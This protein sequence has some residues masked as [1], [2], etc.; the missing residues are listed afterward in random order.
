MPF[1]VTMP[2][3]SP[4]MEEGVIAKWHKK[5]GDLVK[6]GDLLIEVATDKATV[7]YNA[8]DGG[9]L[10][11]IIVP[12]GGKAAIN[13]PVA[14]FS[15]TSD[16]EIGPYL[17]QLSSKKEETKAA[18]LPSTL[19][20]TISEESKGL[21][22]E[23]VKAS[24]LAKKLAKQQGID[25]TKIQGSGPRGRI[26]S[27]DLKRGQTASTTGAGT[28][29][30][31]PL[32]PMRKVIAQRLTEAKA[33]IP[34]IY[35]RQEVD[36]LP[37]FEMRQQLIEGGGEKISFNDFVIK[38]SSL[39]LLDHPMLNSGFHAVSQTILLFQTV[40]ISI[41]VTVPGGL[42]TPIVRN[43]DTKTLSEI[44]SEVKQ[45]AA[46]A[47]EGKL[48]PEEY[49]GGSFTISNLGMFGITDFCAIINPP[50]AAIL[51]V[52]GID[53]TVRVKNGQ[54]VLGK[55][56]NLVLSADHRVVDGVEAAQF[57]KSIQKYLENPAILCN[58]S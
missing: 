55:K 6:D 8:L 35:V 26:V 42:M 45:L 41:A 19:T 53:D 25:L 7:E 36:A 47:K 56:M 37:L 33:T 50:Q 46:K 32:T 4:T 40:D 49:Q 24:P 31:V 20:V 38:A 58:C 16:E 17:A 44:S 27:C 14:V 15:V 30:E 10:R 11:K 52:G 1:V 18:P 5:E 34:H 39:A 2:K 13:E 21:S 57:L 29:R 3:L 9:F 12:E 48:K 51:A 43:A 23:R 28:Y 22:T 54:F